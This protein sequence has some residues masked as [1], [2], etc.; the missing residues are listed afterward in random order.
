MR[1]E[2]DLG[3]RGQ[4]R[5]QERGHSTCKGTKVREDLTGLEVIRVGTSVF[6]LGQVLR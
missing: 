6:A 2:V 1:T 5:G 4:R 3:S